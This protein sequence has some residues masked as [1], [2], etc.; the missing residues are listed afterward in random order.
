MLVEFKVNEESTKT[1][2]VRSIVII[3]L[4]ASIPLT[5]GALS[6]IP[7]VSTMSYLKH[8][9]DRKGFSI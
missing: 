1:V 9:M 8:L 7:I 3:L 6:N 2:L 4:I 5:I